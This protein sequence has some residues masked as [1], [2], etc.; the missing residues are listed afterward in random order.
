[1]AAVL[2]AGVRVVMVFAF[3]NDNVEI[4]IEARKQGMDTGW[5]FLGL[6]MVS[7]CE[8]GLT[9]IALKSAQDALHGWIYFEPSSV[10]PRSFFDRVKAAS[11][12]EFGQK[13]DNSTVVNLYAANLYDAIMLYATVAG[14]HLGELS[15]GKLMAQAM[16]NVSFHGMTGKVTIDQNGDMKESIRASNYQLHPDGRMRSSKMGVF[17][18]ASR[19]YIAV[20][21]ASVVWPGGSNVPP[22]SWLS[23]DV[24]MYLVEQKR[25]MPCLAGT[26]SPGGT[27]RACIKCS[28]GTGLEIW[29][30]RTAND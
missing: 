17:D 29:I 15:D 7:G 6:D 9:G 14:R 25:C 5:S 16:R 24:G 21:N 30:A 18:G 12:S 28:A 8:E 22:I 10:A 4:A 23:C 2:A 1:M 27:V 19:Q 13:L 20:E 3:S 11:I 26:T